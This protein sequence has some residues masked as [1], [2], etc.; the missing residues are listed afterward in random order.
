MIH[1]IGTDIVSISRFQ[2]AMEKNTKSFLEMIFTDHEIASTIKKK[3]RAIHLA[4]KFAAKESVLKA[5]GKGLGEGISLKEIEID[6]SR[7]GK[8]E[9][10]LHGKGLE[11]AKKMEIKNIHITISHEKQFAVAFILFEN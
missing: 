10:H 9:V 4:G 8:P 11:L 7:T 3:N 5:F 6:N 1:G 2:K